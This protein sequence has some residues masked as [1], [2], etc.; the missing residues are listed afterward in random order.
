[1]GIQKKDLVSDVEASFQEGPLRLLPVI[2]R[3]S[4]I[5]ASWGVPGARQV[6]GQARSSALLPSTLG[7]GI[8]S[9]YY[10]FL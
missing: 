2:K 3:Y 8:Q 7:V 4:L 6:T 9:P 10:M 5:N 1:M